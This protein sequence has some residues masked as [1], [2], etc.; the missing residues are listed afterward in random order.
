MPVF[1]LTD[2]EKSTRLWENH[3]E[4]MKAALERH[5]SI[6]CNCV[7]SHG[8][9]VVKNTGD[10]IFAVFETGDP[11]SCA[12]NIQMTL[13]DEE[14]GELKDIRVRIALHSGTAQKRENDYFGSEVNKTARLLNAGWGGQILISSSALETCGIPPGASIEDLDMHMLKDLEVSIRVFGLTHPDLVM[15]EFPPLKTL[16]NRPNNLPPQIT[17]FIGRKREISEL[18]E[19]LSLNDCRF[20]TIIGIGGIGKTRLALQVASEL[21]EEFRDGVFFV[22]LAGISD[23]ERVIPAIAGSL[24][25]SFS[26]REDSSIELLN[27]L[28]NKSMLLVLD[29]FE[30]IQEA[31]FI[32][33]DILRSTESVKILVTSRSL[34]HLTGEHTYMIEGL[35]FPPFAEGTS[36]SEYSS[37]ELFLE[38]MKRH[39]PSVIADDDD[40]EQIM[41]ICQ[42]IAGVPLGIELAAAW[43]R[44][45]SF[46]EILG[47]IRKNLEL[48]TSETRDIPGRHRSIRT[49]F[50]YSW[51]LLDESDRNTFRDISVF[52][53]GFTKDA[54]EEVA[55]VSAFGLLSLMDKSLL[56]KAPDGRF[57]IHEL[58][59]EYAREKAE[60]NPER[61]ADMLNSHSEY[62]SR[63]IDRNGKRIRGREASESIAE[64]TS[65]MD[66][67]AKAL[68]SAIDTLRADLLMNAIPTYALFMIGRGFLDEGCALVHLAAEAFSDNNNNIA[69]HMKIYEALFLLK[70]TY[71]EEAIALYE[72][73]IEIFSIDGD[74]IGKLNC[75]Y[76]LGECFMRTGRLDKARSL[77]LKSL[78]TARSLGNMQ[79]VGRS[80]LGLGN[81]EAHARNT[82]EAITA[83]SEAAELFRS[84]ENYWGIISTVVT[85]SDVLMNAGYSQEADSYSK[86]A[87]MYAEKLGNMNALA[88]ALSVSADSSVLVGDMPRALRLA[89]RSTKLYSEQ[90]SKWGLQISLMGMA[91]SQLAL[92]LFEDAEA[93]VDKALAVTEEIGFTQN[94]AEAYFT[95]GTVLQQLKKPEKALNSFL[96]GIEASE[97]LGITY[98]VGNMKKHCAVILSNKKEFKKAKVILIDAIQK[99]LETEDE[100]LMS[101]LIS[102]YMK[103]SEKM[104]ETGTA[105]LI[106]SSPA[107]TARAILELNEDMRG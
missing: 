2:I 72:K 76:G 26:G 90:G 99:C 59:R 94:S 5:D 28:R 106:K 48:L 85:R 55:G 60:E 31:S 29:N 104:G 40:L 35:E 92:E 88:L 25:L 65:E 75:E 69:S 95:A 83:L 47:E 23:P 91:Q 102:E 56:R 68:H 98:N 52:R 84:Q 21:L 4:A 20:V 42:I 36:L 12:I 44:V 54:A 63:L 10:G 82:D 74:E 89:Q 58:L 51:N 93:S 30:H 103:L 67:I 7:K 49:V 71:Y 70:R 11:L 8:G 66:N 41:D 100:T 14:W 6:L 86:E 107:E 43:V 37:I 19:H 17:S 16:S 61:E 45:L 87:L 96:K 13:Q 78:K 62:Y 22:P 97:T 32:I 57:E 1:L 24:K 79:M 33:S 64:L 9:T 39:S 38:S 34:L 73:Q 18:T 105:V 77:M 80:L 53:G 101:E 15:K 27:F 46:K 3:P 81:T 50:E